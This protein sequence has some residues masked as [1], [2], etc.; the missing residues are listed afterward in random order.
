M[1]ESTQRDGRIDVQFHFSPPFYTQMV[2]QTTEPATDRWSVEAA[3]AYMDANDIAAGILSVST[4][5]VNFLPKIAS[6]LVAR[7][8]NEA[9]VAVVNGH[10]DRFGTFA[11]L[12]MLDVDATL[13]EIAYCLDT[14][15]MDG[16]C[17]MSNVQGLYLGDQ[18]FDP[19]FDELN[20]RKA[21]V[22]IHPTDPAD[23][24]QLNM[25]P[26]V[27][28]PFDTC[29][30]AIDLIYSGTIRR[31]P[32]IRFI[33]AHAGGALPAVATRIEEMAAIY[34]SV[35]PP[36]KLD[37]AVNQIAAFYYDL[38]IAAHENT[39]GALRAISSLDHVLFA[40]D[41][42]FAPDPAVK[43]NIEGFKGLNLTSVERH[44]IERSNAEA[45]FPRFKAASLRGTSQS[46]NHEQSSPMQQSVSAK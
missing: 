16:V 4:P 45:L 38:A 2:K 40:C 11:T 19:I 10:P 27:E 35:K 3:L 1:P 31:C 14:L 24:G 7:Q 9:A 5:G 41:W 30:A 39:I 12:P 42:P 28:W 6:T 8:L 18:S 22:F 13:Q 34:S 36:V 37:E 20:R 17:M 43:M 33:L 23:F 21:V 44:S 29:R 15:E 46:P 32:D 26:V 25:A